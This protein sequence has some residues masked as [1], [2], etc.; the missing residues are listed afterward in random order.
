MPVGPVGAFV[1]WNFPA[2]GADAQDRRGAVGR[3]L[4]RDQAVGGGARHDQPDRPGLRGRRAAAGRPQRPLRG[5]GRDLAAADRR[6]R[7]IRFVAFT[8]SV[9]VGKHIAGLAAAAMKPAI[10][11]LGG[12]APVIVCADTDPGRP[13]GPPFAPRSSTPAR[14]APRRA[15]SSSTSACTTRLRRGLRRRDGR[16]QGRQRP[17]RGRPDGPDGQRAAP[18]RGPQAHRGRRRATARRSRSAASRCRARASSTRR[19][20]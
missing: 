1:P 3:L 19:R 5:A 6:P 18:V 8:G 9:P 11:E 2:G 16:H 17:R 14:C 4:D 13:P 12:H 7:P 15:G 20:C 10:M